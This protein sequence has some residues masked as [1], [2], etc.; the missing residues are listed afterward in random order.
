MLPALYAEP[1]QQL[2]LWLQYALLMYCLKST[3]R[4]LLA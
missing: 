1:P 3:I 4:I 2:L